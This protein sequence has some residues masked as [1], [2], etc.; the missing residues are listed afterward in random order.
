M[1]T[2]PSPTSTRPA[3][4]SSAEETN[5]KDPETDNG[6]PAG[7][8]HQLTHFRDVGHN[9]PAQEHLKVIISVGGWTWSD[10]FSTVALTPESRWAFAESLKSFVQTY[11]LDGADLDWEY[12]TGNPADCGEAGNTCR[13]EDPVNHA[14]LILAARAKLD[15]LGPG[16]ELSIAM[17]ADPAKIARIMPPMVDNQLLLDAGATVIMRNPTALAEELLVDPG[18]TAMDALNYLHVMAYEMAGAGWEDTARHHAPLYGYEG[19]SGDPAALDPAKEHLLRFNSHHAVQAYRYV[20]DDYAAAGFDPDT[21]AL[22]PV[23]GVEEIPAHKLVLGLPMF[24]R[25]FDSVDVGSHDG[26]DGL[27][28]YTDSSVR[29]RTPKGTYDGGK[30]G[31]T[32]VFA[33]WDILLNHG[34]D[35]AEPGHNLRRVVEPQPDGRSYGPYTL[36]GDLFIGFDDQTSV[37]GKMGYVV[38]QGLAGAMFW[39]LPGD[40]SQSLIDQ[41]VAGAA[42][43]YPAKSLIDHM[44]TTLETLS[45]AP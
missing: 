25:A 6:L 43:A 38:D 12:P 31:N 14:L 10:D 21:P 24:G 34:G 36:E 26:Y 40:L 22:D 4:R 23:Y 42:A 2:T 41:G 3:T 27:F 45:P 13:P 39:D 33:Y 30:W 15:E 20:H 1:S 11:D 28:Q 7:N 5:R 8:L 35:E 29:R 16:K 18:T 32:G 19:P 37:A 17:P 44:A 9:G